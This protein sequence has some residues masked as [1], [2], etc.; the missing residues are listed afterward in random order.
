[1][2]LSMIGYSIGTAI[3]LPLGGILSGAL[4]W[5][6]P[7]IF[8]LSLIGLDFCLRL[9]VLEKHEVSK[10]MAKS[11]E[12][13]LADEK[14]LEPP[15]TPSTAVDIVILPYIKD[16]NDSKEALAPSKHLEDVL[17]KTMP[18]EGTSQAKVDAQYDTRRAIRYILSHGGPLTGIAISWLNGFLDCG[19][20]QTALVLRLYQRYSLDELHAGYV[21]FAV[22]LPSALV[23][24]F[25]GYLCDRIGPRPLSLLCCAAFAPA[26]LLLIID[27]LP[28]PAFAVI[29]CFSGVCSGLIN[30]VS[31]QYWAF[32]SRM[33]DHPLS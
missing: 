18:I 22:A 23:S 15:D 24:P 33:A 10:W 29:L 20:Y 2:G 14:L 26:L 27:Q 12:I 11:T 8:A 19:I 16:T 30:T 32:Y 28:L 1:M 25:A 7:S 3:G 5:K 17:P 13:A 31:S 6:G 9:L 4:G 21:F